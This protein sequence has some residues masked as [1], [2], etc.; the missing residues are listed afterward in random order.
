MK[1][2]IRYF[3]ISIFV[4]TAIGNLLVKQADSGDIEQNK[5]GIKSVSAEFI[6]EKH[7]K[8]LNKPLISRGKLYYQAPGSLRWEYFTPVRSILL[9]D[10]GQTKRYVVRDQKIIE[11]SSAKMQSMQIIMDEITMWLSGRYDENPDFAVEKKDKTTIILKP[12][13]EAFSKIINRIEIHLSDRPGVINS[14]MIH[15]SEDSFTKLDFKK[16]I[17]NEKLNDS[18]FK[19]I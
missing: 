9:V 16:V 14:V 11:D 17:L 8:I 7:L 10:Q 1:K 3:L 5:E 15:E 18:L 19:E 13:K 2:T 12:V 4:F 6:Q